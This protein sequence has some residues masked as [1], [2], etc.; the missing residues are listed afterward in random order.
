MWRATTRQKNSKSRLWSLEN[1]V[2]R[3]LAASVVDGKPKPLAEKAGRRREAELEVPRVREVFQHICKYSGAYDLVACDCECCQAHLR[4]VHGG[5][6]DFQCPE[7]QQRFGRKTNMTVLIHVRRRRHRQRRAA[8]TKAMMVMSM[9]T[10]IHHTT[11]FIHSGLAQTHARG[12]MRGV[13]AV[14]CSVGIAPDHLDH[15]DAEG[16]NQ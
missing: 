8:G 2:E 10:E 4:T 16:A 13:P 14:Q 6:R 12:T 15:A 11:I 5:E 9:T 7:C 1:T 3:R